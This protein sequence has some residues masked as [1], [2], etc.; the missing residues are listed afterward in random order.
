MPEDALR[1]KVKSELRKRIRGL[2]ATAPASACMDRSARIVEHL[3][4]MDA[5]A[6]ARTV[7]L[8]WPILEKH[9]VDLRSLD[10]HLRS[11]GARVAY[12]A[13][14]A[15]SRRMT[16][17]WVSSPEELDERGFGFREPPEGALEC[18]RGE[19]EVIV[20]P[21]I[22]LAPDGHRIGYGAGYYDRALP[23][24]APPA[25]T[26]GVGYDY[27]LLAEVPFTEHDVPLEWVVTDARALRA[28]R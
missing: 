12:P 10:A 15:E 17:R 23:S 22:V 2:R 18:A 1:R 27:Q 7:A 13:I 26:I 21:A 11:R 3:L 6:S 19:L 14:D 28:S 24:F 8:F 25:V 20:V 5:V 9:E 16:F 4:G